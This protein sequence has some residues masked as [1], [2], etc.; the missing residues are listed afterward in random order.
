[1]SDRAESRRRANG[2]GD[3]SIGE[4]PPAIRGEDNRPVENHSGPALSGSIGH[5][6]LS[7]PPV[8]EEAGLDDVDHLGFAVVELA[9]LLDE[10]HRPPAKGKSPCSHG[11]HNSCTDDDGVD[12]L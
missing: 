7:G 5:E 9:G 8:P 1:M 6:S 4:D 11:P 12:A 10:H 2:R 3:A